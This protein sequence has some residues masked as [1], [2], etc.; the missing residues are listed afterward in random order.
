MV[1]DVVGRAVENQRRYGKSYGEYELVREHFTIRPVS[2]D[3]W[4]AL[5][6]HQDLPTLEH[7]C[8]TV[9]TWHCLSIIKHMEGRTCR[10]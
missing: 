4:Q 7:R 10:D 3:V 5:P 9:L 6:R 1:S 8:I 2:D